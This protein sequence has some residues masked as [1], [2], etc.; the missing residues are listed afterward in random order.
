MDRLQYCFWSEV[1]SLLECEWSSS[2]MRRDEYLVGRKGNGRK[3]CA[4]A[5]CL[6]LR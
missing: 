6:C 5:W 4:C 2:D 1:P 3:Y